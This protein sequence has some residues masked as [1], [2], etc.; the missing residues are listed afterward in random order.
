MFDRNLKKDYT[1]EASRE[2]AK[3]K[4]VLRPRK[5]RLL[6]NLAMVFFRCFKNAVNNKPFL[7]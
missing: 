3:P 2:V 6:D 5:V 1:L 7:F 4:M